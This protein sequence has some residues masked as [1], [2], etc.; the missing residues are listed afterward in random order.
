MARKTDWLDF[1]HKLDR[2][3]E[4]IQDTLP[5]GLECWLTLASYGHGGATFHVHLRHEEMKVDG[6]GTGRTPAK[7]L[8]AAKADLVKRG[9]EQRKRPMLVNPL[10]ALKGGPSD[11]NPETR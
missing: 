6:F 10:K 3:R 1:A 8:E 4:E 9:E 2:E 5:P 11:A 7:A